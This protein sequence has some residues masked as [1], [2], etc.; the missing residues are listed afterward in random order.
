MEKLPDKSGKYY[1]RMNTV[2]EEVNQIFWDSKPQCWNRTCHGIDLL[3]SHRA[4]GFT[5]LL[6]NETISVDAYDDTLALSEMMQ[7]YWT[8]F[9]LFEDPNDDDLES[10][11]EYT[12]CGGLQN[13]L[14]FNDSTVSTRRVPRSDICAFWD[15][16]GYLPPFNDPSD[17]TTT[18]TP[19]ST[20]LAMEC[21]DSDDQD[22]GHGINGYPH[23]IW[24]LFEVTALALFVVNS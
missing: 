18:A 17:E 14:I 2:N 13:Q 12:R 23:G 5:D 4:S 7:A 8:N 15:K 19:F 3:Y 24:I 21:E 10:W 16:V 20:T 6:D 22:S 11:P 9:A 1:Y